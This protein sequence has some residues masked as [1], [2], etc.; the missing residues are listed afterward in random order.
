[1][2]WIQHWGQFRATLEQCVNSRKVSA[3]DSWCSDG[4]QLLWELSVID[5]S[6]DLLI[7]L[8]L[9]QRT[10]RFP[11]PEQRLTVHG[12]A[13][14]E[15]NTSP[16]FYSRSGRIG[17][18]E[19][20]ERES[21]CWC[22]AQFFK[23][24][25]D[26]HPAALSSNPQLLLTALFPPLGLLPKTD[27]FLVFHLMVPLPLPLWRDTPNSKKIILLVESQGLANCLFRDYGAFY[28]LPCVELRNNPCYDYLNLLILL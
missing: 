15:A 25:V 27:L 13:V 8:W 16:G 12:H 9:G 17:E 23:T 14:V 20:N 22:C 11:Q 1:M 4:M 18:V 26:L 3:C 2:R 6:V 21:G 10:Q 24:K 28:A 7:F 5:F 19:R